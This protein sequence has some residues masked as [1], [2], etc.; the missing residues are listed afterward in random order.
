MTVLVEL[1][2][3][4]VTLVGGALLGHSA[5]AVLAALHIA[6]VA[7]F[8]RVQCPSSDGGQSGSVNLFIRWWQGV[9][10]GERGKVLLYLLWKPAH[11]AQIFLMVAFFK[12]PWEEPNR[13]LLQAFVQ[14]PFFPIHRPAQQGLGGR[15]R[16]FPWPK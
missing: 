1:G 4:A 2:M 5:V 16:G 11:V 9:V 13:E 7:V 15:M 10:C 14:Q 3:G 6:A 8:H 12:F